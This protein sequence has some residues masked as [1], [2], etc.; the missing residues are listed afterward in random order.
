MMVIVPSNENAADDGRIRGA[1]L[2]EFLREGRLA[3]LGCLDD[4]GWP[5]VV[6][7][8]HEW[9]GEGFWVI[10]RLRSAWRPYLE[11]DPRCALTI[12]EEGGPRRVI[13]QCRAE[14]IEGPNVGGRWVAI[15]ERM[16][17]RYMGEGGPAYLDST[18][19]QKRG[20]FLLRPTRMLTWQG[21][22]WAPRYWDRT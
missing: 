5:Y 21:A 9:D 1:D 8:W 2:D 10:P 18:R 19:S 14:M 11:R 22:S 3:R 6:P 15:A 17:V 20:L 12:E 13:A 16:A 4:Q 7:V